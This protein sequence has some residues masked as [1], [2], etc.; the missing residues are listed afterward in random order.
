MSAFL[1]YHDP[2]ADP[3]LLFTGALTRQTQRRFLLG[4]GS[5]WIAN[6]R[7]AA[8][9]PPVSYAGFRIVEGSI[10]SR[11]PA[12]LSGNVLDIPGA[13]GFTVTVTPAPNATASRAVLPGTAVFGFFNGL[14]ANVGMHEARLTLG[15]IGVTFT[16]GATPPLYLPELGRLLIRCD[17]EP[18]SFSIESDPTIAAYAGAASADIAGWALPVKVIAGADAGDAASGGALLLSAGFGFEA[19]W[20]GLS[21]PLSLRRTYVLVDNLNLSVTS[22][23]AFPSAGRHILR[24]GPSGTLAWLPDSLDAGGPVYVGYLEEGT[25]LKRLRAIGAIAGRFSHLYTADGAPIEVRQGAATLEVIEDAMGRRLHLEAGT[26]NDVANGRMALA[27]SNALLTTTGVQRVSISGKPDARGSIPEGQTELI[28]GVYE[29]LPTLPDPYASN[30]DSGAGDAVTGHLRVLISWATDG[31]PELA[32]S[33]PVEQLDGAPQVHTPEP[34]ERSSSDPRDG[35]WGIFHDH[36]Q[37]EDARFRQISRKLLDVSGNADQ[38]GVAFSYEPRAGRDLAPTIQFDGADIHTHGYSVHVFALP[39]VQWEPVR[40]VASDN[41]AAFGDLYSPSDGPRAQVGFDSVQLVPVQPARA[42]RLLIGEQQITGGRAAVR[43]TLPFGIE[44]VARF[45]ALGAGDW[46][47]PPAI[48]VQEAQFAAYKGALQLVMTAGSLPPLPGQPLAP[49]P[50]YIPGTVFQNKN[51][52]D[53]TA[54]ATGYGML[55]PLEEEFN[56]TF[57]PNAGWPGIPVSRVDLSG[58]GESCFSLWSDEETPPPNVSQVRFDVINGRTALEVVQ[59]KVELWPCRAILVRTM[60]M[61]RRSS[62]T[63]I[64][65]DSGWVPTTPGLFRDTEEFRFHKGQ[66]KGMYNIRNIRETGRRV[67]VGQAFHMEALYFDTDVEMDNVVR[68]ALNGRAPSRGQLG[69]IQRLDPGANAGMLTKDALREL[70]DLH[71]PVGGPL[72]CI[73]DVNGSGQLMRVS[74]LYTE[75]AEPPDFVVP[76]YGTLILEG[77]RQWSVARISR[78]GSTDG[79]VEPIGRRGV[80]LIRQ[81]GSAVARFSDGRD[82]LRRGNPQAEYALLYTSPTHRVLF[83]RIEVHAAQRSVRGVRPLLAD[84]YSMANAVGLFPRAQSCLAAEAAE[85]VLDRVAGGLK[86]REPLK[87]SPPAAPRRLID[88]GSWDLSTVY[89]AVGAGQIVVNIDP[90]VPVAFA[91]PATWPVK[92]P[93]VATVLNVP[94]FGEIIRLISD[95]PDLGGHTPKFPTPQILFGGVLSDL[96]KLMSALDDMPLPIPFDVSLDGT[97][98]E[99]QTFRLRVAARLRLATKSGDRIDVGIGKLYG[100]LRAGIDVDATL[101]G[102]TRGRIFLELSGDLQQGI[103]PPLLFAGGMLRFLISVDDGGTPDWQLDV[104]TVGSVGGD[105]ISGLIALEATV[106]YAYLLRPDLR[107][108]VRVGMD[109]RA[110]LLD[111]LIGV[112]FGVDAAVGI[113]R[114]EPGDID[115]V[116]IEGDVYAMGQIA[117]V[118]VFEEEFSRHLRF[119]QDLRLRYVAFAA[120]MNSLVIPP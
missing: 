38:L 44:A 17:T 2:D 9:A 49:P 97:G 107:P 14:H 68:G 8:N 6:S 40:T 56:N 101:G 106:H 82:L 39:Q 92:M 64:R 98:V 22:P 46:A 4:S 41:V 94:P 32:L 109:A 58:Y 91:D 19:G 23:D 27:V 10:D 57:G 77:S 110:K 21:Q 116:R 61:E 45:G 115:L 42:A 29:L 30:M 113:S 73:L 3:V 13:G 99:N 37:T 114:P 80:P 65:H 79:E 81:N 66:V 78:S 15:A 120:Y 28:Y 24:S 70:L 54:Q 76:L 1:V 88:T 43:F 103:L 75:T 112:K 69:F 119:S 96:K 12:T 89:P 63:V 111:G 105:L 50:P 95:A 67:V 16:R 93:Q 25:D 102:S 53:A 84:P 26:A 31:E 72:D 85:F 5:L 51:L 11:L 104:G 83:P 20:P 74:G 18:A 108:G 48:R 35:L 59:F 87:V 90:T 100:E 55:R 7:L 33:L 62:A 47:I 34:I 118:W 52:L 60:T 117:A 36:V 86:N 71:G